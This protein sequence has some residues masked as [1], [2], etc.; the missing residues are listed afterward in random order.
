MR[1][2]VE[3]R[4]DLAELVTVL[5]SVVGA[6]EEFTTS[7]QAHPEV[8]LGAASVTTVN[9]AERGVARGCCCA[10]WCLLIYI[11]LN[12]NGA[13]RIPDLVI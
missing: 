6:E 5:A 11:Q 4:S 7:L 1:L 2:V 3:V 12:G 10:H 8:G 13:E 9:S